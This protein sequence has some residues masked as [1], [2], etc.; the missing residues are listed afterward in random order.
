V[1]VREELENIYA[2]IPR[3]ACQGRCFECCGP[4]V[5]HD[6]EI[7]RMERRAG[8]A[9]TFS[10][11][12]GRCGYLN[13]NHRCDVYTVRPLVCR[14]W[15]VVENL[16][17]LWGCKPERVLTKEEGHELMRRQALILGIRY[18]HSAP[19]DWDELDRKH[20]YDERG[21]ILHRT[22]KFGPVHV[23]FRKP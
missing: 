19:T 13:N 15:G 9:L 12:D 16:P 8:R 7:A 11:D 23:E 1:G 14:L 18:S 4:I 2:R 6:D 20:R 5:A 17:C 3:I 21:K 10:S 22:L